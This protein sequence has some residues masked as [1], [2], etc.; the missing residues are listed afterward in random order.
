MARLFGTDGIRGLANG[1][2]TPQLAMSVAQAAAGVLA[3]HG[4]ANGRPRAVVGRDGRAS[5]EMLESAV[6]AGLTSAGVDVLRVGVLPTPAVAYLTNDLDADLGVMLSASHNPMP[7]NG[8]K[9]FARGGTKLAD[10]IEEEVE[11][12]LFEEWDRPLGAG[13]GRVRD[14]LDASVRY[15]AHLLD[16]LPAPLTGLRVVVDCANG[17][18]SALAPALYRKAGAEVAAVAAEPN[19][20]NIND[21]CG[22]THPALVRGEVL[23][24]RADV[25]LAHDGDAD[26]CLAVDAQGRLV[27]GDA[28]LA[29]CALALKED[30]HLTDDTVVTTVMTNMGF[31]RAMSAHGISVVQTPVGDR[32]VLEAM[33]ERGLA[34]GGEQSGHLVFARHASTGDGMLTAL[35]LLGR[36]AR[37]GVP[38]AELASVVERMP[39]VL[40]NVTVRDR[41][42]AATHPR[43]QEVVTRCV[44]ALGCDGRLLLR[45]SGTE[46]L[47]RVMVEALTEDDAQR[48]ARTVASV[49]AE[50]DAGT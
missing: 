24:R 21:G 50:V 18:A 32:Y 19:G 2:L 16:S 39:Q 27:D 34:L 41:A 1:D 4:T 48:W 45:A 23:A 40:L 36:V 13:V 42:A 35:Q 12:R 8:I 29:V 17:A 47:V 26:R 33:A 15:V 30:G 22:S 44:E 25:G 37:T 11:A 5:G 9:F 7:D 31:M 14:L 46:P 38:L 28:I 6:V 10:A 43:V 49:V 3:D 20:H